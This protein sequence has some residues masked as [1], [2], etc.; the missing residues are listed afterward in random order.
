MDILIYLL[1]HVV[2]VILIFSYLNRLLIHTVKSKY[3][4]ILSREITITISSIFLF[5][6]YLYLS[7]YAYEPVYLQESLTKTIKSASNIM[8][9]DCY[10]L[11]Y[12]LR[13]KS[14]LDG[15]MW[16]MITKSSST[17]QNGFV[18]VIVWIVFMIVNAFAIVG[19][20]RFIVQIVYMLNE[21][22]ANR[23]EDEQG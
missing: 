6:V 2:L 16:W 7:L 4:Y 13:L 10:Y 11:D 14:E 22:F 3:L 18:N 8:G 23:V 19:I 20:N 1:L 15:W 21:M 17:I 9:S 5:A 12:V